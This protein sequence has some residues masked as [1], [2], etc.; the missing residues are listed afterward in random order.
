MKLKFLFSFL[1]AGAAVASAQGFKDG[2]QYYRADQPEEA[3]IILTRTL[4]EPSTDISTAKYYLGQIAVQGKKFDLAK[5]LFEEGIAAN[6]ENGF[7]YVG[8]GELALSQG[9]ASAAADFFKQ[10]RQYGKKDAVMITD[11]ARAYY[12]ADPEKYAKDIEKTLK[13]AKKANKNCPAI[14]ILEADML[15]PK[16]A[17]DAAGYY[18][19]AMSLD[20]EVEHPEAYVKYARTYFPVSSKFA[21]EGI[22]RLVELRPQS[23]LA[24]RELAEKYYDN[25]QFGLAAEQYG[26]YIQNPN[27][28]KRDE[29]RYALLLFFSKKYDESLALTRKLL[30]EDPNNF[31]MKRL[32]FIDLAAMEKNE[33]AAEK[34]AKFIASKGEFTPNDLT[35]YGDVLLRL[36][37]DSLAMVQYESAVKLAPDRPDLLET[38]SEAYTSAKMYDKAVD[39]QLRYIEANPEHSTNDLMVLA[40][41]YQNAAATTD[42]EDPRRAEYVKKGTEVLNIVNERVPGNYQ[43]LITKARMQLIGNNNEIN[44]ESL[45]TFLEVLAALDADPDNATKRKNDYSFILNSLGKYYLSQKDID[46]TRLYFGRM[47][48]I[49]PDNADLRTFV[50]SLTPDK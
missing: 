48:E 36:G 39:A 15:A 32:E 12:N 24:Q 9:N 23:A 11:I 7:N 49:N 19:M 10:A 3:E 2:V 5:K 31:Y 29:T 47:L 33:E 18:E 16:S 25:E 43:V 34:G 45:P 50:E 20:P 22:K 27:H 4:S 8:L 30:A 1:I 17:G 46:N 14:Y 41:R 37:Q 13:D 26:K 28:F 44:E 40:R 42:M 35:T 38:L 6:P 21:I